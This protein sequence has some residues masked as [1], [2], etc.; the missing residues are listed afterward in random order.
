MIESVVLLYGAVFV[1]GALLAL[2]VVRCL[3]RIRLD[4][5]RMRELMERAA[6]VDPAQRDGKP[7]PVILPSPTSTEIDRDTPRM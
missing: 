1:A 7:E 3:H 6:H 2:Y 4:V 5:S